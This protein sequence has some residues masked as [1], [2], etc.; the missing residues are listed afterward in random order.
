MREAATFGFPPERG[1]IDVP[2]AG[3]LNNAH[4]SLPE[5]QHFPRILVLAG[6][7]EA[8]RLCR[9]LAELENAY[10]MASLSGAVSAHTEYPVPVRT[11]GF[12]GASGLADELRKSATSALIDATHPFALEISRNAGI[13]SFR[14]GVPFA[15]LEREEWRPGPRDNWRGFTSLD[16]AV[17]EL[18]AGSRVLAALGSR[19]LAGAAAE[20][21]RSR[22]DIQVLVRV[23][24]GSHAISR[25]G[26]EFVSVRPPLGIDQERCFLVRKGIDCLLCRNSG[27]IQGRAKL[28]AAADLGIPVHL[29]ARPPYKPPAHARVFRDADDLFN[30]AKGIADARAAGGRSASG[31][32]IRGKLEY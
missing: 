17:R 13:A 19:A 22:S 8:R 14:A 15:R 20:I 6:T 21:L 3:R 32:A 12:G 10:A 11:G 24:E 27:G 16:D 9:R 18:P 30:W 25:S 29:I 28:D 31:G 2:R 1:V 23:I 26:I 4:G 5:S 7:Y